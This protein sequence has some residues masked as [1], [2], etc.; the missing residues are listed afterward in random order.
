[1]FQNKVMLSNCELTIKVQ[2]N[3]IVHYSCKITQKNAIYYFFICEITQYTILLQTYA[4]VLQNIA[5]VLP[6]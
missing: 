6:N 3:E 2:N 4:I 5:K 1:M